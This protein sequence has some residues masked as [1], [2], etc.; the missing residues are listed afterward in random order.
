MVAK[1][2]PGSGSARRLPPATGPA[3]LIKRLLDIAVAAAG[4]RTPDHTPLRR[5]VVPEV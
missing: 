5:P 1:A 2:D 4:P 3:L